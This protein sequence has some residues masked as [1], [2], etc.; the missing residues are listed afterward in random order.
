[1]K[2][3]ES[4]LAVA[5]ELEKKLERLN[6]AARFIYSYRGTDRAALRRQIKEHPEQALD[7]LYSANTLL[8][9]MRSEFFDCC[10]LAV[11]LVQSL[12]HGTK[13]VLIPEPEPMPTGSEAAPTDQRGGAAK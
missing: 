1:M 5:A 3:N 11:D 6:T 2:L 7:A 12:E 8:L 9:L 13:C 4:R 10:D